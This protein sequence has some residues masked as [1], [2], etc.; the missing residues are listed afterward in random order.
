MLSRYTD[1]IIQQHKW[2]I[3]VSLLLVIGLS[4]GAKN[5][6]STNDFRVYFGKD[7]PQLAAYEALEQT[8]G[9]QDTLF[10]FIEPK[11]KNIFTPQTLKLI[12]ELT[13]K[14]WNLPF[15]RRVNSLTNFQYTRADGDDIF[16]DYLLDKP[17]DLTPEKI[18]KIKSIVLNE[19]TLVNFLTDKKGTV[20][21]IQVR[22]D[23]PKEKTKATDQTV[24][25]ARELRDQ[26]ALQYPDIKISLGGS[27]TA[28][29]SLGEAVGQDIETLIIGSY[30]VIIVAL[31]FLL[32]SL[33]GMLATILLVTF[34]TAITM[35]IY[36]WFHYVLTPVAGWVPS[37]VMTIAVADSV[38]ILI[39][40][41]HELRHGVNRH[42]ALRESMR[43]NMN[44]VFIT[45]LTTIIGVMCLNFS[46]SP[47]YRDL[48]NMVGLGVLVAYILSMTFLPALLAWFTIGKS[49]INRGS[50]AWMTTLANWIIQQRIFLLVAMSVLVIIVSSFISRNELTERWHEYF[51][52]TFEIRRTTEAVNQKLTGVHYLRY[53]IDSKKENGIHDPD[54]L[55]TIEDFTNWLRKQNKVAHV[56]SLTDISKRLNKSLHGDKPEWYRLPDNRQLAAQSFLLYET[57]LPRELN[58]DELVNLK[59]SASVITVI[60]HKTD[61]EFLLNLDR[62][63][64]DWL[65]QHASK[66][67]F[68][69]GTGLDM[70]FAHIN[71][72]N[73]RSL[74]KGTALALVLISFVLIFA[75]KSVRL[76]MISLI[77]NLVP[78]ALAYGTWGYFIGRIDLS[79]SIV[80]C[81]SLGIVVDD[82]VHFLSKYL[83]ARREK[84]YDVFEA[85]RYA[86]HT[87]GVALIITTAVLVAGFLVLVASHFSPTWVS[88]LLLAIT[89]SY[90][91]LADFFFLPPLLYLLDSKVYQDKKHT[92]N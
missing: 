36:G 70:V 20:T 28:G 54:Y 90:A 10:F 6:T 25:A 43:I 83:R 7:N 48:G 89:L 49:H 9:K 67:K 15:A 11:D 86:F 41:F 60:I 33:R 84:N 77:P 66:Y 57:G 87:V 62:H 8:Y 64:Q 32:R 17:T 44:P 47:P 13:E 52:N 61:S 40:Y 80:I 85:M 56:T 91:L 18:N 1:W 63:A 12:W 73:I 51:D 81:M 58:L 31:I 27:S 78:A 5:L 23:L 75:L 55:Q 35:G 30:F 3:L 38:H 42:D 74:L 68:N 22:L 50:S 76:G 19:P 72:R 45:S 59:R 69:E 82:T 79:A 92:G 34:S 65:K 26:L 14:A 29:V 24:N 4:A 16:T 46:D 37:I 88:G 71:H 39:S 53:V 21:G 2:I